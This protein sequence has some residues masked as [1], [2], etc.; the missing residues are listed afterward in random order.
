MGTKHNVINLI[1]FAR[2]E[3]QFHDLEYM[4]SATKNQVE[5]F[6]SHGFPSTVLLMYDAI[7]EPAFSDYM[8]EQI[9]AGT[10]EAGI[11][12]EIPK[13]LVEDAGLEWRGREGYTWDWFNDV[14]FLMG[15]T[16]DE[17]MILIDCAMAKFKDVFGFYPEVVGSWHIDA[18]SLNYMAE[19]YKIKG[20]CMCRDQ[21]GTDGYTIWGG[22]EPIFYPCKNNVLCPANSKSEQINVPLIRMLGADPLYQFDIPFMREKWEYEDNIIGQITLEPSLMIDG[23]R[24]KYSGMYRPWAKWYFDVLE[25]EFS[26]PFSYAQTG[27]ENGFGWFRIEQ[28]ITLQCEELHERV[29]NGE[30]CVE[31]MSETCKWFAENYKS[32]PCVSVNVEKDWMGFNRKAIWYYSPYYRS[33]ILLDEGTAWIRELRLFDN[34][35]E[36]TYLRTPCRTSSMAYDNLPLVDGT[37][38]STNGP[39]DILKNPSLEQRGISIGKKTSRAGL[40]PVIN[41]KKV[42]IDDIK[43][44][45][46]GDTLS[47]VFLSD[48][49]EIF[50]VI[51]YKEKIEI[52]L[53]TKMELMLVH[54]GHNDIVGVS[55]KSISYKHNGY[56]YRLSPTIGGFSKSTEDSINL[57]PEDGK[58]LLCFSEK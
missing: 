11:W 23:I 20:S 4:T 37:L 34:N 43:I 35:Y 50:E 28:G 13:Q 18:F 46:N 44:S 16:T 2:G 32:T 15:Y 38:W 19:K 41:D 12:F 39:E 24:H 1:T 8:N 52:M 51:F 27:Q 36:E 33:S 29:K 47:V 58:I 45:R 17:R 10:S 9:K 53:P 21:W 3:N 22:Y 56:E 14:G 40:Y 6:K 48:S 30:M 7:I 54:N 42:K 5:L 57:I 49:V 26:A 31:S 25:N 55:D